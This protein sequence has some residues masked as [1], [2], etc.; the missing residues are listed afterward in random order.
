MKGRLKQALEG[1]KEDDRH[2]LLAEASL[3]NKE[4]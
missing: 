3:A 1:K 4:T 2:R